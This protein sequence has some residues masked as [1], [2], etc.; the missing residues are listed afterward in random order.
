MISGLKQTTYSGDSGLQAA[1]EKQDHLKSKYFEIDSVL[2][3]A[4][5]VRQELLDFSDASQQKEAGV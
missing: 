3:E 5:E 1:A 2:L 4:S